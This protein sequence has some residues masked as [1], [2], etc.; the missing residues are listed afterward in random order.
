[1]IDIFGYQKDIKSSDQ[2]ASSEYAVLTV[3]SR[4]S[5]VQSVQASYA[6][7]LRP[8]FEVGA[9][10]VYWVSGH[11]NGQIV[12]S[13]LVGV[14]GFLSGLSGMAGNCGAVTPVNIQLGGGPCV[15]KASGSVSFDGG[16]VESVNF[17]L[18]AGQLE[19]VEG[20]TIRVAAMKQ[21]G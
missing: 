20:F 5:L 14:S 10:A 19:I 2:V 11:S 18:S 8:L 4:Q 3:G 12:V 6:R 15:A 1:M 17:N 13:R 9:P 21:G 16:Q 7:E